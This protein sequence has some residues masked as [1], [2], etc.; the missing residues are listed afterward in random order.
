MNRIYGSTA[1]DAMKRQEPRYDKDMKDVEFRPRSY[2]GPPQTHVPHGSDSFAWK[3]GAAVG[4]GVLFAL[5]IFNAYERH[6]DRK[7]AEIALR[8]LS[9]EMAKLEREATEAMHRVAAPAYAA[10]AENIRPV[11]PGF[12]CSN[13]ILLKREA[14][15]WTQ[16]TSRSRQ[17]Y[18]PEGGGV[19]ACYYVTPRSVGCGR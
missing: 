2:R 13:G 17:L 9:L 6:Q 11:P 10:P 8:M 14:N 18:C 3:I 16:I 4:I 15:G 12:R 1:G 19:E 5:L 7:D